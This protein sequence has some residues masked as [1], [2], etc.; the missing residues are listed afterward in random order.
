MTMFEHATVTERDR[1]MTFAFDGPALEQQESEHE[2]WHHRIKVTCTHNAKKKC[3]EAHVSWCKAAHRGNFS[4]EQ[5]AIFTDPYV[6]LMR[7]E[8]VGRYSDSKFSAFCAQVVHQC[9]E[10]V[11]D[12][13]NTN[14]VA[15]LLRQAQ[16]F[17]L[18]KN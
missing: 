3:Y 11:A 17:G 18:V 10:I 9:N 5:V 4:V 1:K 2:E 13:S 15:E 16:S 8:P 14:D 6:L 7:S 12:E